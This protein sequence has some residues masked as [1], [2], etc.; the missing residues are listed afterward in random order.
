MAGSASHSQRFRGQFYAASIGLLF[1]GLV[2]ALAE[3]PKGALNPTLSDVVE[4]YCNDCHDKETHKGN[5]DLATAISRD[6]TANPQIWEKVVR[7]IRARQM[8]P[9]DKKRPDESTYKTVLSELEGSLDAAWA[10]HPNPGRTDT[11]RRL[12]RTEYQNAIRDLLALEI[13]AAALLP[14]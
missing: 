11:F 3:T 2:S 8:P 10:Q 12:N 1:A 5:L 4:R 7:R 14:K 13:D 9:A 6:V